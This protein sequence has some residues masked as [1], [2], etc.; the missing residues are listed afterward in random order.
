MVTRASPNQSANPFSRGGLTD[1]DGMT[2]RVGAVLVDVRVQTFKVIVTNL[3]IVALH[4]VVQLIGI[5][6]STVKRVTGVERLVGWMR[7]QERLRFIALS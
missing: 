1:D 7:L 4:L 5:G 6:P 2:Q 3:L